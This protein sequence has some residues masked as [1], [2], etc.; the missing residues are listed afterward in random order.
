MFRKEYQRV[1]GLRRYCKDDLSRVDNY[2]LAKKDNFVGW[3]IHHRLEFTLDGERARTSDEL[4]RMGM[5]YGRPYFELIFL[6]TQDHRRLH[7][8]DPVRKA[9][10][11]KHGVGMSGKRHSAET[12]LKMRESRKRYLEG[13]HVQKLG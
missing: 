13:I 4:I 10:I 9:N 1:W 6:R 8:A 2:D 7:N 12:K 11:S 5:Y 3:Q